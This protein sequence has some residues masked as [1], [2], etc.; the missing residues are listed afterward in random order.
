[1]TALA[2]ASTEA[3]S[4]AAAFGGS[5]RDAVA[6]KLVVGALGSVVA[7]LLFVAMFTAAWLQPKTLE[8]EEARRKMAPPPPPPIEWVEAE[9]GATDARV[10]DQ[11]EGKEQPQGEGPAEAP[12]PLTPTPP[13]PPKEAPRAAPKPLSIPKAPPAPKPPAVEGPEMLVLKTLDQATM[14]ERTSGSTV[15]SSRAYEG[16]ST[17]AEGSPASAGGPRVE[18]APD[19]AA[20]F[21]KE[22]PRWA[23]DVPAWQTASEGFTLE[24]TVTIRLDETGHVDRSAASTKPEE[25][26]AL[27]SSIER[28]LRALVTKLELPDHPV[29]AGTLVVQ[30]RATVH[31]VP[32]REEGDEIALAFEYDKKQRNGKGTFTKRN[33]RSVEFTTKVV[34]VKATEPSHDG[35]ETGQPAAPPSASASGSAPPP[36]PSSEERVLPSKQ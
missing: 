14:V 18:H 17:G 27:L 7:H 6:V 22:L 29:G 30:V 15:G 28:T 5:P 8:E 25:E 34:E 13:P 3:G 21:T 12:A 31:D 2:Q 23:A 11:S 26:D 35:A 9:L 4:L 10:A 20:R 36:P 19:L 33:G 1:M 24:R 32:P 16:G